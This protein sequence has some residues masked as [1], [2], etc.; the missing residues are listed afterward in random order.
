MNSL[1]ARR[2]RPRK[3]SAPSRTVTLTL[4][5]HV[6]DSL[7]AIAADLGRAV[8]RLAA[9]ADAG[10]GGPPAE[11]TRFGRH[12]VLVVNPTPALAERTGV[13]LVPL[14]D[15]RAIIAFPPSRT[16]ADLELLLE[17]ALVDAE[18]KGPDRA[19]FESILAIIRDARRSGEVSLLQ[20][21]IL[22]LESRRLPKP[23]RRG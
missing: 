1:E 17:D 11:L 22:L 5:L 2:G 4:P 15:G 16:P 12:A 10:P 18:L 20:R 19:T 21:S 8:V 14:P 7:T 9:T 6:I 3:F 23:T 13:E